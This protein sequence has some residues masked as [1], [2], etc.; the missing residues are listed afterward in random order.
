MMK[1]QVDSVANVIIVSVLCFFSSRFLAWNDI[2]VVTS[3]RKLVFNLYFFLQPVTR[4]NYKMNVKTPHRA[5]NVQ[6][7]ARGSSTNVCLICPEK[8][9]EIIL[10]GATWTLLFE[11]EVYVII[12]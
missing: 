5:T 11:I 9:I 6:W 1:S 7:F 4:F 12:S 3:F 2:N 10:T 8:G